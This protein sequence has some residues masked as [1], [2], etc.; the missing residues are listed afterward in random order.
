[1]AITKKLI[2][3]VKVWFQIRKQQIQLS[4]QFKCTEPLNSFPRHSYG[5]AAIIHSQQNTRYK[6]LT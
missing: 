6:T 4:K 2:R 3:R 5:R 1:M